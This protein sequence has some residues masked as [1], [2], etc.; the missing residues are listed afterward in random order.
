MFPLQI[1]ISRGTYSGD[2]ICPP[3]HAV[4]LASNI[5]TSNDPS[6]SGGVVRIAVL[7]IPDPI[8]TMPVHDGRAADKPSFWTDD[9]EIDQNGVVELESRRLFY[10]FGDVPIRRDDL[11]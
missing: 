7:V 11:S 10:P 8:V 5:T 1:K 9:A 2:V 6:A 4:A 3:S